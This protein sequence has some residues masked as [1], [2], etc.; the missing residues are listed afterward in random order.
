MLTLQKKDGTK[1]HFISVAKIG[2][3]LEYEA[4]GAKITL[5]AFR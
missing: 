3:K 4:L 5:S 1:V 2:F